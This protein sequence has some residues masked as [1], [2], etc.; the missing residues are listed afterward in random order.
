MGVAAIIPAAGSGNRFGE[1]K[2]FKLLK[3]RPLLHYAIDPFTK[4]SF[5]KEIIVVVSVDKVR[6]VSTNLISSFGKGLITVVSGGLRRQDSVEEGVKAAGKSIKT[7]CIHDAARPFITESLIKATI[8]KCKIADGAIVAIQPV[9]TVKKSLYGEIKSTINRENIWLAQTPQAFN[10]KKLLIA[11]E[12]AKDNKLEVTD[13]SQLM[14]EAGFLVLP[15]LGRSSN[16][17]VTSRADWARAE[18]LVK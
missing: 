6:S 5:I 18:G 1:E 4:L 17:K 8:D 9:D 11:Y 2:Q 10:K 16:F 3:G 12:Y 7:I 15:V 14:E 13:E